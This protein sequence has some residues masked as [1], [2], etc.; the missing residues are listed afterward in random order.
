MYCL[1]I[2]VYYCHR[3]TTQLQLT[4]ISYHIKQN[5]AAPE[6]KEIICSVVLSYVLCVVGRHMLT[7]AFRYTF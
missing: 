2:N 5:L 3:V 7:L 6:A 1:C 4:N